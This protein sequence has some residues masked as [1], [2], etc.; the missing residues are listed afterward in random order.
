M[1][2][3]GNFSGSEA[4]LP[5]ANLGYIG[6]LQCD[7]W[8]TIWRVLWIVFSMKFRRNIHLDVEMAMEKVCVFV[9]SCINVQR[10]IF[11]NVAHRI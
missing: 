9:E 5:R 1:R 11:Q 7:L 8:T 3:S 2:S 4:K 10:W 6:P